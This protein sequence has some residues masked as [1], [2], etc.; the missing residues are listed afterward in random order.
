MLIA[1]A[2]TAWVIGSGMLGFFLLS[3]WPKYLK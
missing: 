2:V 3:T 1:G